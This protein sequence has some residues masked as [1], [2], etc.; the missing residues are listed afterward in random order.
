MVISH[1][2]YPVEVLG[3]GKRLALW[4]QGCDRRCKNCISPELQGFEGTEYEVSRLTQILNHLIS[5]NNMEGVTI[6]G[7]EPFEQADELLQLCAGLSCDDIL[8]YTGYSWEELSEMLGDRI[9]GSGISVLI[10]NPYIENLN[11]DLPLRGSSNQEFIFLE[12]E[13]KEEY[14]RYIDRKQR[15]LQFFVEEDTVYMAGI[16]AMGHAETIRNV[17]T[18]ILKG[19]K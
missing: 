6:S 15:E 16:P 12:P 1:W 10:T 7:G 5:A 8:V 17:I 11:D 19:E 2:L 14:Y 3:P 18:E 9:H 4:V 13:K